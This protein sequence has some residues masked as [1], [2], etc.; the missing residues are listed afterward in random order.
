MTLTAQQRQTTQRVDLGGDV[1][2]AI[3]ALAPAPFVAPI[4]TPVTVTDVAK[5]LQQLKGSALAATTKRVLLRPAATG[6]IVHAGTAVAAT[7][8]PLDTD[9]WVEEGDAASLAA[10]TF[11]VASGTVKSWLWEFAR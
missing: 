11:I 1:L 8:C 6:I 4:C 5:T 3:Q 9:D 2:K 7:H 10:V